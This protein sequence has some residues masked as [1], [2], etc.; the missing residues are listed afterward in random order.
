MA[1]LDQLR[2]IVGADSVSDNEYVRYCYSK[3]ADAVYQSKPDY[4]VRPKTTEEVSEIMR[5][6]NTEKI[7][8]V[9]R[10]GGAGLMGGAIAHRGGIILDMT[11]MRKII[12]INLE[13]QV[14]TAE[15]GITWAELNTELFKKGFYT[16]CLGP[17]SGMSA[18]IGGG[19]SHNSVGGGGGAKYG[20]CCRHV[21]GLEVVLPQGDIINTGSLCC[22]YV[23]QPFSRYGFGAD[24]SGLFLGDNGIHGV[25]TR[26]TLRIYPRPPYHAGKTFVLKRSNMKYGVNI[27][28][29]W[30]TKGGFGIYDGFY[31]P[32][33][34]ILALN[35]MKPPTFLPWKQLKVSGAAVFYTTEAF[36]EKEL[37]ANVA[38]LDVIVVKNSGTALGPEI[39]DGNF[40]KYHYELNGHWS[41]YQNTFGLPR[42]TQSL[43]VEAH[44]PV[45]KFPAVLNRIDKWAAKPEVSRDFAYIQKTT[46][47]PPGTGC[48]SVGLAGENNV[49]LAIGFTTAIRPELRDLN[50]KLWEDQLDAVIKAGA[51]HYML[52]YVTSRQ[53]VKSGAF[54]DQYYNFMKGIKK[55]LDP[56]N[57]LSPG[58]FMFEME[59][60]R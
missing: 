30:L 58:I 41:F 5:L 32:D 4:V 29:E 51:M 43:T 19:L 49:E 56:N 6:A 9:A 8:V 59:G 13:D 38:N 18:V 21:V 1:V 40:A 33:Y 25:K 46:G 22:K 23:E 31:F 26:A 16:G 7:P 54:S 28:L 36:S 44:C 24:Y 37:E 20:S 11:A 34:F 10:G 17:G 15:C 12:E 52:G 45:A 57:I 14:V 35:A 47:I 60:Y 48:G 27:F 53:L 50:L 39:E 42:G 3:D 55:E 2:T